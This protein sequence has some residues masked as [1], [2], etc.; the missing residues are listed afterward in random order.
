[1]TL[2]VRQI[3]LPLIDTLKGTR[4]GVFFVGPLDKNAETAIISKMI[5]MLA[6]RII[7]TN[8]K[9]EVGSILTELVKT[10]KIFT[11]LSQFVKRTYEE[12]V[13]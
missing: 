11:T 13:M 9:Q 5:I 3:H 2:S 12:Y 4:E 6:E 10:S 7:N 1:M 8:T